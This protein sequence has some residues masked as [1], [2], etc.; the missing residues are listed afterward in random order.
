MSKFDR[1]LLSQLLSLFGF[2]SLVLV[3]VYWVNRAVGLFDQLIGDGQSALVFLEFTALTLP[4]VIRL[5][6]P[7]AAFAAAIYVTNRL[8]QE[9]E[10]VVMQATGFS[11]WRLARPVLWFGLIVAL[12]TALLANAVV[13]ASR[14][15]LAA[16]TAEIEANISARLLRE[17][18]FL[19]PTAGVTFYIADIAPNGEMQ[20][21]FLSD[22]RDPKRSVTYS[23]PRAVLVRSEAGPKLV[24]LDGM[25]Q[26]LD[27]G[28]GRLQATRFADFTYDLS[29]FFQREEFVMITSSE[30]STRELLGATEAQAAG[31]RET[32][33]VLLQE[34]HSR[35]ADPLLGLAGA[36]IGFASLL[37][38]AF[39]RFGLW[40]QILGAVVLLVGVQMAANAAATAVVR[41]AALWP[42]TYAPPLLGLGMG[43]GLLWLAGKP[44]ALRWKTAPQDLTGA[45]A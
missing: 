36:L 5:V 30:M 2:F 32:R 6:L 7:I 23:A 24:M 40:R 1:Y 20:N 37:V 19:H 28:T 11:P 34:G 9:S 3:A 21:I 26:T 18:S 15:T 17:G 8:T 31:M 33:G 12:L 22:A 43:A 39:S 41:D 35:I 44:R 27:A 42:L 13:P 45:A 25:A 16:R 10:L 38:G 29:A 14:T 4:N